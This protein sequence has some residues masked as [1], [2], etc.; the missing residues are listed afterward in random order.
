[1]RSAGRGIANPIAAIWAGAM[2]PDLGGTATI[3]SM[4]AAVTA[5]LRT[6]ASAP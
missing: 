1:L 6:E 4:T 3:A 2:T 5:A